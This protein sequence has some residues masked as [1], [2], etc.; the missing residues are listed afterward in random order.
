[1]GIEN[2]DFE[3]CWRA[4]KI[5]EAKPDNCRPLVIKMTDKDTVKEWT[6]YGKGLLLESR[7]WVN[8][9]LCA[10]DRRANFLARQERRKRI[11]DKN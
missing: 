7:H 11:K 2:G 5:D 9:D 10:A 6:R 4:G 8:K 1:M 3:Q